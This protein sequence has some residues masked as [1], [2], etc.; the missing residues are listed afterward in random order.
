MSGRTPR[1]RALVA[2]AVLAVLALAASACGG[3]DGATVKGVKVIDKGALTT[4][5][6]LPYPPFQVERGG[7][8]V[9]FDVD[10]IDLVAKRLGLPQKVVDTQFETMKTGAALNAG[11]CD[12]VMGGMTITPDRTQM[13]DV[14][15]PY[16]DATQALLAKKG[17]GVKTLDDVK[18]RKLKIGSQSGTTGEDYVK[19]KGFDP[20]SFDNSNAE[21]DGLRTGQVDVIVQDYPVVRGWLKDPANSKYEI[22]AN[23]NTG[24]KYGFW[25]RKGY[26]PELVKLTNQAIDEAKANGSYKAMYEKWVGPM[27]KTGAG[28]S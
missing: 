22:V 13:M 19:G 10:L 5:T 4:C 11:K 17:S 25:F 15:K 23:L 18:S 26:N 3:G 1:R 7:K 12:L 28:P 16:F 14:S 9:G 24:E 2:P 27:P 6:H 8:V 20:S 21:L